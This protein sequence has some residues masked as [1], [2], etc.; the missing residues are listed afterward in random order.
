MSTISPLSEIDSR[1][2]EDNNKSFTELMQEAFTLRILGQENKQAAD[3]MQYKDEKAVGQLICRVLDH[4]ELEGKVRSI[5]VA[6][7]I[8]GEIGLTKCL[9]DKYR[10]KYGKLIERYERKKFNSNLVNLPCFGNKK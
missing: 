2:N 4:F 10:P 8:S 9:F 1:Q 3:L 5:E 7:A 6:I